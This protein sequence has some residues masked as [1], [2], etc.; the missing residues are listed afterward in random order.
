MN[1]RL[2]QSKYA[3]AIGITDAANPQDGDVYEFFRFDLDDPA[4]YEY[5]YTP[6]YMSYPQAGLSATHALKPK[7]VNKEHL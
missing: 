7:G 6:E 5:W 1:D 3:T 4:L 2:V